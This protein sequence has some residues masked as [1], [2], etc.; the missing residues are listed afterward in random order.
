MFQYLNVFWENGK[1]KIRFLTFLP[2]CFNRTVTQIQIL[3]SYKLIQSRSIKRQLT[4]LWFSR[5]IQK[6]NTNQ[7][8]T[9][10]YQSD[11][12]NLTK[13]YV[14]HTAIFV[15]LSPLKYSP[16][17]WGHECH[18]F[19]RELHGHHINAFNFFPIFVKVEKK[20]S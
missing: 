7:R 1:R 11:L 16:S 6:S 14:Q 10:G 4:I 19:C 2:T 18:S 20:I 9:K 13:I 3:S 12:K 5:W 8:T 17:P 15:T